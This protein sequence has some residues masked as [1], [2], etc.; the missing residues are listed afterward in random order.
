MGI[1]HSYVKLPEGIWGNFLPKKITKISRASSPPAW[2]SPIAS[3]PIAIPPRK[4][5]RSGSVGKT[6]KVKLRKRDNFFPNIL[7][8]VK[9]PEIPS[10]TF[11]NAEGKFFFTIDLDCDSMVSHESLGC[12]TKN[13]W[14]NTVMK[15]MDLHPPKY[16]SINQLVYLPFGGTTSTE[17]CIIYYIC[18]YPI[19]PTI[20]LVGGFNPS[21]KYARQL[22]WLFPIYGKIKFMFQ[23]TNQL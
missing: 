7:G 10:R 3:S 20:I 14:K 11:L 22:G 6:L 8:S 2:M 13:T 16:A 17:I 21:E 5:P 12:Y 4:S 9:I 23:T 1:F 19:N 18:I 15:F